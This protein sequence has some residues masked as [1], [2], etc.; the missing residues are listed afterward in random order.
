MGLFRIVRSHTGECLSNTMDSAGAQLTLTSSDSKQATG[1]A[2][3]KGEILVG[4]NTTVHELREGCTRV[5]WGLPSLPG[6]FTAVWLHQLRAQLR[7]EL[8]FTLP[9]RNSEA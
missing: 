9:A 8:E 7:T 6:Y 3:S 1:A 5:S 2:A 4:V